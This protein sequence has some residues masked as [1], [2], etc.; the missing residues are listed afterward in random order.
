MLPQL[1]HVEN[2]L[3]LLYNGNNWL[4]WF[5]LCK[6]IATMFLFNQASKRDIFHHLVSCDFFVPALSSKVDIDYSKIVRKC[7]TGGVLDNGDCLDWW[8]YIAMIIE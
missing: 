7:E 4:G 3:Y 6:L 8:H 2:E 1:V 5:W